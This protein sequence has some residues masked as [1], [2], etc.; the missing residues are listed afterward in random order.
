VAARRSARSVAPAV[1]LARKFMI[2]GSLCD[3]KATS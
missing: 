2:C 3:P 1:D